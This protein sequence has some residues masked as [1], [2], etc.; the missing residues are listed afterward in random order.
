MTRQSPVTKLTACVVKSDA[1]H[2]VIHLAV[3][4]A[5]EPKYTKHVGPISGG[6][7]VDRP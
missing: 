2:E 1:V 4:V 5:H 3:A 7:E 6:R